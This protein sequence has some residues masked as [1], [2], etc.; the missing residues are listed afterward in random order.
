MGIRRVGGC[1]EGRVAGMGGTPAQDS[2]AGGIRAAGGLP[3][4]LGIV[5]VVVVVVAKVLGE[6]SSVEGAEAPSL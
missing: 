4:L 3:L 2:V 6:E 5:V 1:R